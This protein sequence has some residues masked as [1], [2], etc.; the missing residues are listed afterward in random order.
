MSNIQGK[1]IGIDLGTTNSCVAVM[2]GDNPVVIVNEEGARTTPSVVGFKDGDRLVGTVAKRQA[3]TNPTNTIYS[4]KRFMGS[5]YDEVKSEAEL[6]PYEVLRSSDGVPRV[7]VGDDKFSP[8]EISAMILQKLKRAAEN[9]LGEEV[10]DAVITVPAYFNDAQRQATKDAGRIAGLE[11]HRIINEP[12]AAA[13]AYGLDKKGE[14]KIAVYDFGGGTFDISILEVDEGLVEVLSTNGDTHLG[15]DNVDEI[16]IRW[17]LEEFKKDTG[18]DATK[19]KMVLQRLKES[20]EKAKIE[21]SSAPN[22]EINIPYLDMDDRGPHHL[23]RTLSRPQFEQMITPL[24]ENTLEPCRKALKDAG[25]NP[26]EINEVI[27]VGGSTRIPLVQEKVKALFKREPNR[28]VNPDEVVAMGAAVQGGVLRGD[29]KDILLLDV[30][31]L[32]LGIETMGGVNT[33]LIARNTTIPAKNAMIF[34]TA[35]DNQ[36][37]VDIQVYQGERQFARDNRL[38]GSFRLEGIERAPRGV[39][40]IEVAFDIDANGI[41]KV[42]ATDKKTGQEKDITI[43]SSSGLSDADI[44]RMV[45]EA[46]ANAEEDK[47][48]REVID[49]RNNLDSQVYSIDKMLNENKD[50]LPEEVIQKLEDALA[51]AQE[52]KDSDDPD[53]MKAASE[54]LM[55]VANEVSQM[56][57]AAQAQQGSA[58]AQSSAGSDDGDVIDVVYTDLD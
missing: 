49:A 31:P 48:K 5:R 23:V 42:T 24:I 36:S 29:V 39:P 13:L 17:M 41:L 37:A 16:L 12:T 43:T 2:D 19:K 18:I 11:V 7:K 27:L 9:Y 53:A 45:Q 25:L 35:E 4:I 52:A 34:S 50:K 28:S 56:A 47:R 30:T 26:S 40:Q 32:S 54:D 22:T 51:S 33:V 46:E 1:V 10:T 8:P 58:Q 38:L 3:M 21:L 15:G 55:R 44:D 57:Q 6:M 14:R 20:A